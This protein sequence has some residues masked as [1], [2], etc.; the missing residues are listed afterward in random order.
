[1]NPVSKYLVGTYY[2]LGL[3]LGDPTM[4]GQTWSLSSQRCR[5]ASEK[6]FQLQS[7]F[8]NPGFYPILE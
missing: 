1:M 3:V 2:V 4:P 7:Q 8:Q 5:P 6:E